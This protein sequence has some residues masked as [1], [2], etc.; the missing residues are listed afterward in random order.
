MGFL[1]IL[2]SVYSLKVCFSAISVAPFFL[3]FSHTLERQEI[4][5]SVFLMCIILDSASFS[6]KLACRYFYP[7]DYFITLRK[8]IPNNFSAYPTATTN[9]MLGGLFSIQNFIHFTKGITTNGNIFKLILF[10]FDF[11]REKNGS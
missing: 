1:C 7:N 9:S 5:G 2:S 6:A 11:L 4:L 10:R 3:A 8:D